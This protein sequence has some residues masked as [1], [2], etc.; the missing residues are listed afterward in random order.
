MAELT[1]PILL[2]T[3][4]QALEETDSSMLSYLDAAL[5]VVESKLF[6][7]LDNLNLVSVAYCSLLSANP[8][9]IKPEGHLVT[10]RLAIRTTTGWQ[11]I[12]MKTVEFLDAYWPDRT[13]AGTPTYWANYSDSYILVAPSDNSGR[14]IEL[15]YEVRPSALSSAYPSN[16][17]TKNAGA[18]LFAGLMAEG[19][20]YLKN[21]EAAAYWDAEFEKE[22]SYITKD[23]PRER[24]SN[25]SNNKS[26]S[27]TN[28]RSG[29]G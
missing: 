18:A 29:V 15:E 27:N 13:S 17:Y 23:G 7:R 21:M 10:K 20:K 19:N 4:Q 6:R 5:E 8:Y 12:T 2:S 14:E 26:P 24:R 1:Y 25:T 28:N 3:V 22:V 11:P 16:W 9:V